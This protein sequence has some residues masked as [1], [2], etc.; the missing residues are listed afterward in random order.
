MTRKM[1]IVIIDADQK[2]RESY[3]LLLAQGS[4]ADLEF[5]EASSG[6]E[7]IE[8]CQS[9][10]PDCVLLDLQLSDFH[11]SEVLTRVA[12]DERGSRIPIVL[13]ARQ[14]TEAEALDTL[15]QGAQDYVVQEFLSS[16]NLQRAVRNAVDIVS[17]H[18]TIDAQRRA[19]EKKV[20][21]LA[22]LSQY[23]PITELPNR[24]LFKERLVRTLTLNSRRATATGVMFIGLDDFKVIN[25]SLGHDVGDKLLRVVAKRLQH[26]VRNADTIARWG[27]DEFAIL[28]DQMSKA[29]DADLVAKRVIYALSKHFVLQGHELYLTASIGIA[30]HPTDGADVEALLKNADTAMYRAKGAGRNT[31]RLYSSRMNDKLLGRLDVEARLRQALKREEF[32]LFYQPQLDVSCDRVV[33]L[34]ALIRWPDSEGGYR[35]PAEFIPVLEETGLIVP[36]GEW[37]LRKAC[38]Q[39]RAWHYAGRSDLRVAVNLSA[40]QFRYRQLPETVARILKETG[41]PPHSLE[42]ELTESV[43]AEDQDASRSILVEL[44][45]LGLLVAMDDFGTGYSSLSLL[46]R[47]PVDA[48][49]I[50]RGF[51]RSICEDLNHRAICS[52]IVSLGQA[53]ELDVIAEGVETVGQLNLLR[54]Q[55]CHLVQGYLYARP[56]PADEI[57][58][59]LTDEAAGKLQAIKASPGG[60]SRPTADVK[61]N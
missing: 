49:K 22:Q 45:D 36:V 25:S 40:C 20:Q 17:M 48:L 31:Y 16:T 33:A 5:L 19:F 58:R 18:R 46:T 15:D 11:D 9:K 57:W 44:K 28:L 7:G 12:N 14:A 23:D 39:N 35:L 32:V 21:E 24:S 34:E 1:R 52:A 27:G 13:V 43:L 2:Q 29:E 10:R 55:G 37:V 47:F 60:D 3:R 56:M 61:A 42:V 38:T 30:I 54:D 53:L 26:C 51:V 6:R 50:D 41:L 4:E 8:L 59:W